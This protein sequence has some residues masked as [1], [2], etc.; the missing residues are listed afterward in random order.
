MAQKKSAPNRRVSKKQTVVLASL[1]GASFAPLRPYEVG[2]TCYNSHCTNKA[3]E[4]AVSGV[5]RIRTCANSYCR[6]YA[7]N[8]A[9]ET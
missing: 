3:V 1:L 7:V 2:R 4:V 5:T 9:H 6:L 8:F